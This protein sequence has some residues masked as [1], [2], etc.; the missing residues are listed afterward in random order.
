L[1]V[2]RSFDVPAKSSYLALI[3]ASLLLMLGIGCSSDTDGSRTSIT[4]EI[5]SGP[6]PFTNEP[7]ARIEFTCDRP[8]GCAFVCALGD[9]EGR[10]CSSPAQFYGLE[11]GENVFEVVAIGHEGE[12]S[13]PARWIWTVDTVSPGVEIVS[14]PVPLNNDPSATFELACSEACNFTC[15]L[16]GVNRGVV[17]SAAS[18]CASEVSF[19]HLVDDEYVFSVFATDLAGNG[20]AVATHSWKLDTVLPVIEFTAVPAE[21][22]T[23]N[24]ARFEFGCVN[25]TDCSFECALGYD[26]GAG[27]AML[28][29]WQPCDDQM[30]VREE[31]EVGE[32]TFFVR[33]T[34][35]AGNLGGT[36]YNWSVLTNGWVMLSVGYTNSCA[37]R[38][39]GTLWCWGM[40]VYERSLSNDYYDDDDDDIRRP[41][42]PARTVPLQV[43][44]ADNW[45]RVSAGWGHTCGIRSGQM[46]CWGRGIVGQLGL[47]GTIARTPPTRVGE[48][49]DW[50]DV[51]AS[52]GHTCG[53]RSGQ[54]WCWGYNSEGE[55]G[56][57]DMALRSTPVRVGEADDWSHVST[58]SHHTCGIRS[59]QLW[60]WGDTKDMLD[61][62]FPDDDNWFD[63]DLFDDFSRRKSPVQIGTASDW[64]DVSAGQ[65]HTCGIRSGQVWC[66]GYNSHG[67]L[68][69][70][71]A[72]QSG[73][74][75]R[76]GAASDWSKVS[77]GDYH[78]CG[79]R[80]GQLWCCGEDNAFRNPDSLIA[81]S[82]PSQIDTGDDWSDVAAGFGFTCGIRSGHPWCW[83]KNAYGQL[84]VGDNLDR[85]SPTQVKTDDD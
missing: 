82:S 36:Q 47:E 25:K 51:S 57:G 59:G 10:P 5:L 34:D 72:E 74:P 60:C 40:N 84:G 17:V 29:Q 77:A 61:D 48:A 70:G 49:D 19:N 2:F 3:F 42:D 44:T 18:P 75:V 23:E 64:S 20:S 39:D 31:L 38:R 16:V 85:H 9:E 80:G 37:I 24:A 55:L 54:M 52:G 43:G 65:G 50:S 46:W 13:D 15:E 66:W 6:E 68:G 26:D 81:R 35:G 30:Y 56:L 1:I 32:Y 83:G 14:G 28:D 71:G 12:R 21:Q 76:A 27:E 63:D 8:A 11:D 7:G 41:I 22:T 69:H 79:I 73:S 67:Q 53:I 62:E 4:V 45:T 33:A 78:T 58:G